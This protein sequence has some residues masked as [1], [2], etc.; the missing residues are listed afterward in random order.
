LEGTL[1]AIDFNFCLR[2]VGFPLVSSDTTKSAWI[3]FVVCSKLQE[4]EA[5][6]DTGGV[7][8]QDDTLVR[9]II[10]QLKTGGSNICLL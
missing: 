2:I 3:V 6:G 4:N 1:E 5:G 7:D 10:Y 8:G 9:M